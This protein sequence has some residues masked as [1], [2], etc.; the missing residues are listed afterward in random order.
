[1]T[2]E[3]GKQ[4]VASQLAGEMWIDVHPSEGLIRIKLK[5]IQPP[6]MMSQLI[7]GFAQ[8]LS[9]GGTTFGLIVK[10]HLG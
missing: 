1:M 4:A 7:N 10:Q 8:V 6:E 5:D 2:S 9:T 3:Q